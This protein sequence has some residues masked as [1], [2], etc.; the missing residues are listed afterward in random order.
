MNGP[1]NTDDAIRAIRWYRQHM[2]HVE[3]LMSSKS[4]A[5]S[6]AFPP[7]GSDCLRPELWKAGHWRW[8]LIGA[9][10]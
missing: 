4:G 2:A 3:R 5:D 7:S 10:A 6:G 1:P 9:D 8:L